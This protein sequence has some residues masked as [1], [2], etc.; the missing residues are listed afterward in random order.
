VYLIDN[1]KWFVEKEDIVTKP[2]VI[3]IV[4]DNRWKHLV[5]IISFYTEVH[6]NKKKQKKKMF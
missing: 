4:W 5:F 6:T 3:K 2:E 1:Y